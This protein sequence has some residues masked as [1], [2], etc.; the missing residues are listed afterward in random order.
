[1]WTFSEVVVLNWCQCFIKIRY[2][3]LILPFS[4][5]YIDVDFVFRLHVTEKSTIKQASVFLSLERNWYWSTWHV[6]RVQTGLNLMLQS[7]LWIA[8]PILNNF[9][10]LE[11][12]FY[13]KESLLRTIEAKGKQI[14]IVAKAFVTETIFSVLCWDI[15]CS[16]FFAFATQDWNKID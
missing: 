9:D 2:F 12:S 5:M 13:S 15:R 8:I 10:F 14:H 4:F 7:E 16:L 3:P 1:M 11:L 6:L